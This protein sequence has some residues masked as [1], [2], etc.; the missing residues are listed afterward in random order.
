M[1]TVPDNGDIGCLP[2]KE[3]EDRGVAALS[4]RRTFGEPS[5]MPPTKRWAPGFVLEWMKYRREAFLDKHSSAD[6]WLAFSFSAATLAKWRAS[7]GP[8]RSVCSGTV[9]DAGSGRGAWENIVRRNGAE[10]HSVELAPRGDHSPTWRADICDMPQVPSN[11]YDA[12]ICH[13]VLEH[14][15][16]PA[17]ALAEMHRVVKP[18]GA[19][20]IS[21]PHL[22]RRHELPNDFFRFTPEGMAALA[23]Q[24]GLEIVEGQ[25]YGG[26]LSFLHHQAS[27]IF[28]G[29]LAGIPVLGPLAILAN[30]P[31]TWGFLY[32]DRLLDRSAL[33]PLGVILVARKKCAPAA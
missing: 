3:R 6:D 32:L 17:A 15:T 8:T 18:G 1:A 9:L 7:R 12:I 4:R 13:Q 19:L 27:M 22:S 30:L 11:T 20:V 16:R 33:L 24:A 2:P 10:Y 28:P 29:V 26:P 25:T 31:F 14:V 21:V 23:G 5:S